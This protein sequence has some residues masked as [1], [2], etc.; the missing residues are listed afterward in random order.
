ME[1]SSKATS[2]MGPY[3]PILGMAHRHG[4]LSAA[5]VMGSIC[6]I[7]TVM[8]FVLSKAHNDLKQR[9]RYLVAWNG[10]SATGVVTV[11]LMLNAYVGDFPCFILLWTSYLLIVPWLLTYLARGWRLVYIY[12]RQVDFGRRSLQRITSHRNINSYSRTVN[13]GNEAVDDSVNRPTLP[14]QPGVSTDGGLGQALLSGSLIQQTVTGSSSSGTP[15]EDPQG[16]VKEESTLRIGPTESTLVSSSE[17]P[18]PLLPAP[19]FVGETSGVSN[20]PSIANAIPQTDPRIQPQGVVIATEQERTISSPLGIGILPDITGVTLEGVAAPTDDDQ[21]NGQGGHSDPVAGEGI[22]LWDRYLPFNQATDGRLTV[23]LLMCMIFPFILCLAMQFVKPSPVQ[24]NPTCYKCGEG[25]VFYPIYAVMLAFLAIGCPV[26]SWK[27]W[28]IKDG[29]G[30]RN[31]LLVTMMI[32]LPGF[33]LYFISPFKLKYLDKGHWNHVNWLILTIFLAHVNS[34]VLPLIQ[35]FRRQRPKSRSGGHR[36]KPITGIFRWDSV[37]RAVPG[38]PT[39]DFASDGSSFFSRVSSQVLSPQFPGIDDD[40]NRSI[41]E[42]SV[43]SQA[44]A[45][46]L[47]RAPSASARANRTDANGHRLRGLK[48]FMSKYGMDSDGNFVPLSKMNPRA[49]EFVVQDRDMLEALV[50]FSVTVFST[51]NA[52]FLQEYDGLRKQVR[53]YYRLISRNSRQ[54]S[55]QA[56][57]GGLGSPTQNWDGSTPSSPTSRSHRQTQSLLGSMASSIQYRLSSINDDRHHGRRNSRA[58][59]DPLTAKNTIPEVCSPEAESSSVMPTRP[60]ARHRQNMS[61]SL[62]RLSLQSS[63]RQSSTVPSSPRATMIQIEDPATPCRQSAHIR[64]ESSPTSPRMS[65]RHLPSQS[66]LAGR[67]FPRLAA[68]TMDPMHDNGSEGPDSERSSFS[69]YGRGNSGSALSYHDV[70]PSDISSYQGGLEEFGEDHGSISVSVSDESAVA[71]PVSVPVSADDITIRNNGTGP[72]R[73]ASAPFPLA[74]RPKARAAVS[75]QSQDN[76]SSLG[77]SRS[78]AK[79]PLSPP[80]QQG[81]PPETSPYGSLPDPKQPSRLFQPI[82]SQIPL[83]SPSSSVSAPYTPRLPS[84][85]QLRGSPSSMQRSTSAR[86]I[87]TLEEQR[88][89]Y[90][91]SSEVVS[92]TTAGP[93]SVSPLQEALQQH[94]SCGDLIQQTEPS[95]EEGLPQAQSPTAAVVPRARPLHGRQRMLSRVHRHGLMMPVMDR[96]TPVPKA[97]LPAYWELADTFVMPWSDTQLNLPDE[98]V[99][100]IRRQFE[101]SE[102]Y[103]EMFEPVVREIQELVYVNVWP[104]FVVFLQKQPQ[105]FRGRMKLAW[106][107][108]TDRVWVGNHFA[109]NHHDGNGY[110]GEGGVYRGPT[111]PRPHELSRTSSG[112]FPETIYQDEEDIARAQQQQAEGYIQNQYS[113]LGGLGAVRPR[114][115]EAKEVSEEELG[116]F[117]VMQ[118]LDLTALQRIVVDPQ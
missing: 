118:E 71:A 75:S 72:V 33:V 68:S 115:G 106:K 7:S 104:R 9:G 73:S 23:F 47:G 63:L 48:G 110:N 43:L 76:I 34:V 27:L 5:V 112:Q 78:S 105:G 30:I 51:E 42:Q 102:C 29:F 109:G 100:E 38:T 90:N 67:C 35:F 10:I 92:A 53:E 60:I 24:I 6:L 46:G 111:T 22:H 45:E 11:Y 39:G 44:I 41:A 86:T 31:E 1:G 4:Y 65:E 21:P 17:K 93:L 87:L 84:Q 16:A 28:W 62:W 13:A 96:M 40:G 74:D 8:T 37:G 83:H 94:Q 61:D 99:Q 70:T 55:Q 113:Y 103:L 3:G 58:A 14:N 79:S 26:L 18:L 114:A 81:S 101:T 98:I 89:L 95:G 2:P 91:A 66:S 25:P 80:F 19:S 12:N 56:P 77:S 88:Q 64:S 107:R 82:S 108:F 15:C 20:V 54:E 49:F 97:L 50:S 69:W 117:G 52:L 32:G 116:Q 59:S 85:P 36:G 57:A